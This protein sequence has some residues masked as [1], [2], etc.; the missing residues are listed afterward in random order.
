MNKLLSFIIVFLLYIIFDGTMIALFMGKYFGRV[1][2]KIQRG[3]KMSSRILPAVLCFLIL[4]FGIVYFVLDRIR[5]DH[6]VEDSFRYGGVFGAVVY[7]VFD[8]TNYSIFSDY[9]AGTVLID[10][11]WGTILASVVSIITKFLFVKKE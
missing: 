6:I 4:A 2:E 7:G 1:V 11:A 3:R 10:M 5:D 8:L 9:T